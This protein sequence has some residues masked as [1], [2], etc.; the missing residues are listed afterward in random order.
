MAGNGAKELLKDMS[1]KAGE[2]LLAKIMEKTSA[3][4]AGKAGQK[5]AA[6]LGKAVPV[7]GGIVGG[8]YDAVTTRIAGKV[9]KK[10]FIDMPETKSGIP[11]DIIDIGP[12]QK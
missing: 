2:K 1:V 11:R 5:G 8:S 10:I 9:A 4:I 3:A 7:L 12:Y 6:S